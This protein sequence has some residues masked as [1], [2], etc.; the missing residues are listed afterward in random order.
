MM[1]QQKTAANHHQDKE[2]KTEQA[3]KA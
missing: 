3:G 2:R 1:P